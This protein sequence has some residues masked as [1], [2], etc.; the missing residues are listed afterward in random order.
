MHWRGSLSDKPRVGR[1]FYYVLIASILVGLALDLFRVNAVRALFYAAIVNGV[2]AP[3][4]V[5]IVTKLT[6]DERVMGSLVAPRF[7]RALGWAT[8]IAMSVAAIAMIVSAL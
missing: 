8:A 3:P 6:G 4:L 1:K 2:L 7:V 5:I